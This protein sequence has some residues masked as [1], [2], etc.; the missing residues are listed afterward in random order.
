MLDDALLRWATSVA[1][2]EPD[3]VRGMRQG[4]APWLLRFGDREFVLR[5][6]PDDETLQIERKGL[7]LAASHG[8]P[9]PQTIAVSHR[10][11]AMLSERARGSSAI[12][13]EPRPGRLAAMGALA[14]RLHA[15]GVPFGIGLPERVRPI[16]SI[17]FDALRATRPE[18]P[19]LTRA[20]Q[21][22]R[23]YRPHEANG[24]VHGDLWQGNVLWDG[25]E[26]AAVIDWDCA[27]FGG[28][29]VDLGSAR[30][31]AAACF[32]LESAADVLAGWRAVA[33]QDPE[34]VAYWDVVAA[35]STPPDMDWFAAAIGD[36]GRNDLTQDLLIERRDEFLEAALATL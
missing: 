16:A 29:G 18:R 21:A 14:A 30:C 36:Q 15:F 27:G 19:L 22:S 5:P 34:D 6:A 13:R 33:G 26:L 8:I 9:V 1:G 28:A 3:E 23:S 2:A 32:G 11:P 7:V 35:L 10:P 4:G 12:S 20:V 25:D 17:D 31:D 24:F